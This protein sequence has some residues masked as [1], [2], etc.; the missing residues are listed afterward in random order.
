LLVRQRA[1]LL[2]AAAAL[3]LIA[4]ACGSGQRAAPTPSASPVVT[5]SATPSPSPVPDGVYAHIG[6]SE[7]NPATANATARVYV[8]NSMSNTVDVVDPATMQIVAHYAVGKLPQHVTPSWDMKT[9]YVDNDLGDS[10]TPIDPVTGK[11]GPSVYVLDP[12]NLYFTPDGRFALVVAERFQRLDF[13]DPHT[14]KL[15]KTVRIDHSGPNHLDFSADGRY[16]LISCEFSGYVVK[17][18]V[19]RMEVV[20]SVDVGGKPADVRVSPDGKSFFVTN[21]YRNGVSVIDPDRM[22]ETKFI[23]TGHGAH[24]FVVSRDGKNLYVTNRTGGSVSVLDMNTQKTVTKWITGGS[25]DMGGVSTDGTRLWL[26][27]RHGGSVM[28]IDTRDGRV[29]GR[30]S[31]GAGPHGLCVFPQPGRFSLG[32]TGNYR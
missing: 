19:E 12:Y 32:H 6:P 14:F 3:A 24:G 27:N 22:V 23:P 1:K 9:L 26:S 10:L 28:A 13:R 25:P 31:V 20:K 15:I 29:V 2:T 18:D 7:V 5:A 17:V 30:I 8:P 4:A 16:L 11:R 21:E